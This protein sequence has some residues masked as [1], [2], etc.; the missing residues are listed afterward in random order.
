MRCNYEMKQKRS[1][2]NTK[3]KK[4]YTIYKDMI[5]KINDKI[6]AYGIRDAL[7]SRV[8]PDVAKKANLDWVVDT[9]PTRIGRYHYRIGRRRWSNPPNPCCQENT[10]AEVTV[11]TSPGTTTANT[12]ASAIV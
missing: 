11:P 4:N 10:S 7:G 3:T 9:T 12:A 5:K 2:K 6:R 8:P 1:N